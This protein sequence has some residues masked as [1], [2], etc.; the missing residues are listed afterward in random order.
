MYRKLVLVC[1]AAGIM[2]V[3]E[4]GLSLHSCWYH[5]CI[6]NWSQLAQLLESCMYRK[7]V[8]VCTHCWYHECMQC[9]RQNCS[10]KSFHSAA[11]WPFLPAARL[12]LGSTVR[13][14]HSI[15]HQL[16]HPPFTLIQSLGSIIRPIHSF[17]HQALS[18][19]LYTHLVIRLYH[20]SYPLIQS[21]GSIIRPL[22]SFSHYALSS[23]L[24]L[25]QSLCSIIRLLHP[26]SHQALSTVL[27]THLVIRLHH[28]SFTLISSLQSVSKK[29]AL[30]FFFYFHQNTADFS[31]L[32][33][34]AIFVI[35]VQSQQKK[36]HED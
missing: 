25:I 15:S 21:L 14:L 32:F 8:L 12:F 20:P 22:H 4:T 13:P 2:Y 36:P 28:P 27:Y 9:K 16:Y 6:G 34:C 35:S 23:V 24:A 26:F 19:A 31:P 1:T 11:G 5:V 3:Y 18:S 29:N 7:Q 33:F 30:R 17:N 10:C